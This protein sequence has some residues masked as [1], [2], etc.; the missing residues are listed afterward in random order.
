M[1]NYSSS[2]FCEWIS[3]ILPVYNMTWLIY[4]QRLQPLLGETFECDRME[5]LGWRCVNEQVSHHPPT[6]A[7]H[8]EGKNWTCWQQFTMSS[9]FRGNYIEI[10]PLGMAHLTFSNSGTNYCSQSPPQLV[11]KDVS[12]HSRSKYR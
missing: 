7:Q 10:C 3:Y 6:A 5:D 11:P 4:W 9:K 1:W 2:F 12:C 8:C